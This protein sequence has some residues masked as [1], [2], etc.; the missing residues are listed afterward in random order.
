MD[1]PTLLTAPHCHVRVDGVNMTGLDKGS[2]A[3][4][5][6]GGAALQFVL[7]RNQCL[8]TQMLISAA[9]VVQQKSLAETIANGIVLISD[10][11][12][13]Q[14]QTTPACAAD[15]KAGAHRFFCTSFLASCVSSNRTSLADVEACHLGHATGSV[16]SG[17]WAKYSDRLGFKSGECKGL[18]ASHLP[19]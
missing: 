9:Q 11:R 8:P 17:S 7:V 12:S 18:S 16:T 1:V 6:C 19:C 3:L 14:G 15:Q 10:R 4:K 2:D 5:G 13:C